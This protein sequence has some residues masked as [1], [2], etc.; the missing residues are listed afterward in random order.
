MNVVLMCSAERGVRCAE[1][2]I[3]KLGSNDQLAI[4]T[5]EETPWEPPYVCKLAS[6]STA[7]NLDFFVTSKVHEIQH[8]N[9]L[10][11]FKPDL[12]L[13]VGWR[14]L[15]PSHVY[16]LPSVGTFVF[17]DSLLPE[18]RGFS[19]TV[20]SMVN[21]ESYTGAS[22]FKISENMDEGDIFI[23]QKINISA[24]EDI[25]DVTNRVTDCYQDILKQA[26]DCFN[27]GNISLTPQNH[28]M[29]T[30]T[31]KRIPSDNRID[32]NEPNNNIYNLIRAVTYPYSGAFCFFKGEKLTIWSAEIVEDTRNFVGKVAGRVI[33][34]RPNEGVVVLTGDGCLLIK[35]VSW[36]EFERVTANKVIKS[37]SDTLGSY[38]VI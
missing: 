2:L 9:Y 16:N 36:R 29:A 14:Y 8:L 1:T 6:L 25:A 18:Y 4:F 30:Y 11:S 15:V 22:L 13:L 33:E 12:I 17:H 31:C 7:H 35:V 21:G 28:S 20:W 26:I 3:N 19:P 38:S 37:I 10:K 27:E 5:F 32:F 23:Q 34:I 24:D